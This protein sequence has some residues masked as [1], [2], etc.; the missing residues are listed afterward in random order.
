MQDWWP[1]PSPDDA[2]APSRRTRHVGLFVRGQARKKRMQ[3]VTAKAKAAAA[4]PGAKSVSKTTKEQKETKKSAKK[5][6]KAAPVVTV[7]P[8]TENYRRNGLGV[9]LV[10]QQMEQLKHLDDLRNSSNLLFHEESELC[11]LTLPKCHGMPWK[12][13]LENAHPFFK[14]LLLSRSFIHSFYL[15]LFG[16]MMLYDVLC[17]DSIEIPVQHPMKVNQVP[18][19]SHHRCPH[20]PPQILI[21]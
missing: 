7:P 15:I 18:I 14:S 4:K 20:N 1:E 9:E 13:I 2:E 10:K 5:L 6:K 21:L 8:T 19:L 12:K 17:F 3:R 16:F 11:R